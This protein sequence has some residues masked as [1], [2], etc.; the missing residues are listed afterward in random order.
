MKGLN[1]KILYDILIDRDLKEEVHKFFLENYL[2][3]ILYVPS[4]NTIKEA[5]VWSAIQAQ[6]YKIKVYYGEDTYFL[7]IQEMVDEQKRLGILR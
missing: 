5:L 2:V 1:L 4:F 7:D 6:K 3:D